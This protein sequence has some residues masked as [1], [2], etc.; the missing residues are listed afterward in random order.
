M[1]KIG[2]ILKN[3]EKLFNARTKRP[4]PW[5]PSIKPVDTSSYTA[6]EKDLSEAF[7]R[8]L[9]GANLALLVTLK[10]EPESGYDFKTVATGKNP[11]LEREHLDFKGQ[12]VVMA[13]DLEDCL[14]FGLQLKGWT[15]GTIDDPSA[16]IDEPVICL[17]PR[18]TYEARPAIT[19]FE[20]R[21]MLKQ[22]MPA[23]PAIRLASRNGELV[24]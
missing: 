2:V 20:L 23:K 6:F 24:L 7:Q 15:P 17:P 13:F 1:A 5:E 8:N 14:P 12:S 16:F 19:N 4:E 22:A 10:E 9:N 21:E 11:Y 3:L 18:Q